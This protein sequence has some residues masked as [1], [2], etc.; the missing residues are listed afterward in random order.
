MLSR[1]EAFTGYIS[2]IN[3]YIQKIERDEM[4]KYGLKGSYAQYLVAMDNHA[5]GLSAAEL[6]DICDRDKAAVS[7]II[8]E[9]ESRGLVIRSDSLY[10]A[11]LRLSEE[12]RK[13]AAFVRDR[14]K[15]A[16]EMAGKG[17]NDNDR[18]S[19]YAAL[20]L[21]S[22]NLQRICREGLKE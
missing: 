9:M 16:V 19:F 20:G 18:Q 8:S 3:R 21:I 14:A 13:A 10:R 2:A 6:C 17:L 4:E 22:N 11:K 1:F 15:T 12:G 7:R 5:D